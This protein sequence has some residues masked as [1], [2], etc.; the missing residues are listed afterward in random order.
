MNKWVNRM[1]GPLYWFWWVFINNFSHRKAISGYS[2]IISKGKCVQK[3]VCPHWN[4]LANETYQECGNQCMEPTCF[5]PDTTGRVCDTACQPRCQ[6][7]EGFVRDQ[8]GNCVALG[9]CPS[10]YCP[11]NEV[12]T[13]N[14]NPCNENSCTASFGC[15]APAVIQSGC[16]CK[17]G[18]VRDQVS[19]KR[20]QT[21]TVNN[22]HIYRQVCWICKL[23]MSKCQWRIFIMWKSM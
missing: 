19:G 7:D 8:H 1:W 22:Q 21:S 11:D 9:Q 13:N 12:Y 17:E 23:W 20:D 6:C 2:N 16:M 18:F 5:V 15:V 3:S 14:Y 4:C 10:L